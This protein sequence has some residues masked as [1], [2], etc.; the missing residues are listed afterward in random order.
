[1]QNSGPRALEMAQKAISLHAVG[2][3]A[4]WKTA[5]TPPP[6]IRPKAQSRKKRSHDESLACGVRSA[7]NMVSIEVMVVLMLSFLRHVGLDLDYL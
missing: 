4:L 6:P 2:V 1:M 5:I 7:A 3:Q